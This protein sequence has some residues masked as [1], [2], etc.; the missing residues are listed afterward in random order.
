MN[1]TAHVDEVVCGK[2]LEVVLHGKLERDD[3]E[4]ILPETER[5]IRQHGRIRILITLRDFR[6]WDARALWEDI[7]WNAR[8]FHR[9]ERMA[10]VGGKT[11]HRY[12]GLRPAV[13]ESAGALFHAGTMRR[14]QGVGEIRFQQ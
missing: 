11:W 13:H 10:I 8:Y 2:V 7:R 1:S 5:M 14:G 9:V 4:R 12:D 6:G 3:D